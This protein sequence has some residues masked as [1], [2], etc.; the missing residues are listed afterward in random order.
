MSHQ[1][2][3]FNWFCSGGEEH[4]GQEPTAQNHGEIIAWLAGGSEGLPPGSPVLHRG[5]ALR[6]QTPGGSWNKAAP[7]CVPRAGLGM[8]TAST[9]KKKLLKK[10]QIS[11]NVWSCPAPGTA[12]QRPGVMRCHWGSEHQQP[13]TKGICYG[14]RSRAGSG[15]SGA[16]SRGPPQRQRDTSSAR[17]CEEPCSGSGVG[18]GAPVTGTRGQAAP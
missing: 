14:V 12:Q 11:D 5:Q 6:K 18:W 1:G 17:R 10:L 13:T 8:A 4:F 7:S 2:L 3:L 16:R 15:R 9:S